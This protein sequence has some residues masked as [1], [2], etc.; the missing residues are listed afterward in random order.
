MGRGARRAAALPTT[1]ADAAALRA[2]QAALAARGVELLGCAPLR[3]LETAAFVAGRGR[4]DLAGYVPASQR[5]LA[6]FEAPAGA[7]ADVV[8][9]CAWVRQ[10]VGDL[11]RVAGAVR[12]VRRWEHEIATQ[13]VPL[14]H[15]KFEALDEASADVLQGYFGPAAGPSAR[16]R[17]W[18]PPPPRALRGGR[19]A[20]PRRRAPGGVG[21][22]DALARPLARWRW[23][24]GR[25]RTS[26]PRAGARGAQAPAPPEAAEPPEP[27]PP[28]RR[29]RV[30]SARWKPGRPVPRL[31]ERDGVRREDVVRARSTFPSL[32]TATASPSRPRTS[33]DVELEF[34]RGERSVGCRSK[35]PPR[36]RGGTWGGI[37]AR[38]Q[39][40]RRHQ[41]VARSGSPARTVRGVIINVSLLSLSAGLWG[42]STIK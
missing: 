42:G 14:L 5:A 20:A 29:A 35:S 40:D 41:R 13:L 24:C 9:G 36:P 25:S 39:R 21:L 19:G 4:G 18:P 32:T 8:E 3:N 23:A 15:A 31:P 22:R 7:D 30:P 33:R 6:H 10:L 38:R 28:E 11:N 1:P 34:R 16:T 12:L 27:A 26:R 37:C 17:T 2:S